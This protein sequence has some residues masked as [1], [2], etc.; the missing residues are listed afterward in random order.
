MKIQKNSKTFLAQKIVNSLKQYPILFVFQYNTV[1]TTDL[2]F[3]RDAKVETQLRVVPK[4]IQRMIFNISETVF[5]SGSAICFLG[6]NNLSDL[7]TFK[8][9]L[10]N[11]KVSS[12]TFIFLGFFLAQTKNNS[13]INNEYNFYTEAEIPLLH[14]SLEKNVSNIIGI[15]M[16]PVN[17]NLNLLSTQGSK[18]V[19]NLETSRIT[20]AHLINSLSQRT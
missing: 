16:N 17:S 11:K 7:T 1:S 12:N 3:L 18:I 9:L 10:E 4:S 13:L 6:A 20:L 15:T 8:T 5:I 19:L 2:K 14:N